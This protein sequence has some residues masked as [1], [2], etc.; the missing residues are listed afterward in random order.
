MEET[1]VDVRG[2]RVQLM[3]EEKV[4]RSSFSTA[5]A[6]A[7][8]CPGSRASPSRF[9]VYAPVHPGSA[10]RTTAPTGTAST[11]TSSTISTSSTP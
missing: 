11:T 8:G 4:R 2:T 6:A 7:P 5:R 9:H 1:F 10:A 3:S